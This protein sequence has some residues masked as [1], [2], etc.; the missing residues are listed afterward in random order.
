MKASETGRRVPAHA[1][2]ISASR[3]RSAPRCPEKSIPVSEDDILYLDQLRLAEHRACGSEGMRHRLREHW[4]S[5]V[6][7][8]GPLQHRWLRE[9][10]KNVV[11]ALAK[12]ACPEESALVDG[13]IGSG[14]SI[15][16]FSALS[17]LHHYARKLYG[18]EA[19]FISSQAQ[20]D[21]IPRSL[22]LMG[23]SDLLYVVK[24]H[25]DPHRLKTLDHIDFSDLEDR[26]LPE[27][28]RD[29]A[30]RG[31][32][33]PIVI[34]AA[35]AGTTFAGAQDD[36]HRF[37]AALLKA[38]I[39]SRLRLLDG[40]RDA[41]NWL[42]STS[43]SGIGT[44]DASMT[45]ISLREAKSSGAFHY[46]TMSLHK[47]PGGPVSSVN[48]F[49]KMLTAPSQWVETERPAAPILYLSYLI[50]HP[51]LSDAMVKRSINNARLFSERLN[52]LTKKHDLPDASFHR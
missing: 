45:K 9:A 7:L 16:N 50:E 39:R 21:S 23:K 4:L 38:G 2:H 36:L 17:H 13:L 28:K 14:G 10:E 42:L 22:S 27:L 52:A 44:F 24:V 18:R 34:H 37:D 3:R 35:F 20:H 47:T 12:R 30:R 6:Y 43:S 41:S 8:G 26:V 31:D 29:C 19:V 40:A 49:P 51:R 1:R 33:E 5:P 11:G 32:L 46:L 48:L 25:R 15:S